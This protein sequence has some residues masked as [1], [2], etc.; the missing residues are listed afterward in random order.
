[1]YTIQY[2]TWRKRSLTHCRS[3]WNNWIYTYLDFR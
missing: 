2:F 3:A 1:M